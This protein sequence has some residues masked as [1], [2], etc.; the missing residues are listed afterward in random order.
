V[1]FGMMDEAMMMMIVKR[2]VVCRLGFHAQFIVR[3]G[4]L[5]FLCLY[6]SAMLI[7]LVD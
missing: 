2:M 3:N 4:I 7:L 5:L 1:T 6:A